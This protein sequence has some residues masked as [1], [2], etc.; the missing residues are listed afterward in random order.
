M[1]NFEMLQLPTQ[2]FHLSNSFKQSIKIIQMNQLEL[3]S[4][5]EKEIDLN[6]L[7]IKKTHFQSFL[8]L[9]IVKTKSLYED[10]FDQAAC[11]LNESEQK[12]AKNLIGNLSEEGF[13]TNIQM[14][15][16]NYPVI[17]KIQQL[18]PAG[19]CALN[20]QGSLLLQLERLNKKN[21]LAYKIIKSFFHEFTSKKWQEI[22]KQLQ[23]SILEIKHIVK[24]DIAK[25]TLR[26]AEK[27]RNEKTIYH[28]P[29]IYIQEILGTLKLHLN[30]KFIP[31]IKIK[32]HYNLTKFNKMYKKSA[33]DL[34]ES[35]YRRDNLL[36]KIGQY[37]IKEQRNFFLNDDEM[38][39]LSIQE[40]AKSCKVHK[41][42]IH[43]CIKNKYLQYSN[44]LIPISLFFKGYEIPQNRLL[45]C[46]KTVVEN[47]S[48]NKPFSDL[49]IMQELKKQKIAISR[50]T[51]TKYREKL[52]IP[53]ANLRKIL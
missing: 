14:T 9:N 26:P 36:L 33:F 47:E 51:V 1:K 31:T 35:L 15:D 27:Y 4:Y 32:S 7:I 43:R 41:S 25:L 8:D 30:R 17:K 21:T 42:T 10:L 44:N 18:E 53:T 28:L 3:L 22:A 45:K 16:K 12:I 38:K 6:P 52:K 49:K 20:L 2:K 46:L 39:L 13:L 23:I 34:I 5:I 29:D 37:L 48:K 11:I 24:C 19:I 50:R 40:L